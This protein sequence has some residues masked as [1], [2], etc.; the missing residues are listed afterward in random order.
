MSKLSNDPD[1]VTALPASLSPILADSGQ[2][3]IDNGYEIIPLHPSDKRPIG[4]DWQK[5]PITA[6]RIAEAHRT[7][8]AIN[9]G[10]RT[11]ELVAVDIDVW[12]THP[13]FDVIRAAIEGRLGK[14][15]LVRWGRKGCL[16]L[17]RN[18]G[19]PLDKMRLEL[20]LF[21]A[22]YASQDEAQQKK[23]RQRAVEILGAPK[24]QVVL[25]GV[26]PLSGNEYDWGGDSAWDAGAVPTR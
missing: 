19:E 20:G 7:Y 26:H 5:R 18:A 22:P 12:A 4:S 23:D 8:G 17:Y 1:G 13:Q 14:T 2:M 21:D 10:C 24:Y 6:E 15:P 16:L 25:Y 3:L 11:G 9:I